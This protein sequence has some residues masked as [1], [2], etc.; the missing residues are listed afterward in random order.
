MNDKA[1]STEWKRG[2]EVS[3]SDTN[4]DLSQLRLTVVDHFV[5]CDLREIPWEP[6]KVVRFGWKYVLRETGIR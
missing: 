1:S 4:P 2:L 5:Y 3:A 6:G